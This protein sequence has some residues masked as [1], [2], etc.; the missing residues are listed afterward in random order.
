[1]LR[2]ENIKSY[3][4]GS[5]TVSNLGAKLWD[6]IPGNIKKTESLQEFKNKILDSVK[7]PVQIVYS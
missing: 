7:L 4:Y 6:I 3:R 2:E 5:E 1:M